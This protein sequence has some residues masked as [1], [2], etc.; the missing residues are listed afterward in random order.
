[1]DREYVTTIDN[2]GHLDIPSEIRERHG[3]RNGARVKIQEHGEQVILSPAT[4]K[5]MKDITDLAGWMSPSDA[6]EDLLRERALD[7]IR[8]DEKFRF[9]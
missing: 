7:K 4:P 8:E 6:V 3:M 2:E 1:M 5:K 9:R